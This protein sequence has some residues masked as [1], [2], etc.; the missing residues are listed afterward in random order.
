MVL[1]NINSDP[2][3]SQDYSVTV[4]CTAGG[5][6]VGETTVISKVNQSMRIIAD[7]YGVWRILNSYSDQYILD[8][9]SGLDAVYLKQAAAVSPQ[10]GFVPFVNYG[11]DVSGR[12][13]SPASSITYSSHS[14]TVA[15]GNTTGVPAGETNTDFSV[16]GTFGIC[17]VEFLEGT[18]LISDDTVASRRSSLILARTSTAANVIYLVPLDGTTNNNGRMHIVK[19]ISGN[20]ATHNI[21]LSGVGCTI[22]GATTKVINTNYGSAR[23]FW[24]DGAWLTY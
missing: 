3:E 5:S 16:D 18:N 10:N 4:T 7:V 19:D 12:T 17:P 11:I 22:D 15:V 8:L 23:I 14:G 2:T 20:A 6:I 1:I 24:F 21:T 13:L 9:I